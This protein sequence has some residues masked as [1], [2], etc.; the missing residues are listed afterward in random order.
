MLSFLFTQFTFWLEKCI[1]ETENLEERVAVL[2]RV[3][4]LLMVFDELNNFCGVIEVYSALTSAPVHRLEHTFDVCLI[5]VLCHLQ[6][7]ISIFSHCD[8]RMLGYITR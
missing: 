3:L 4:E 7:F 2:C 1:L 5:I 6:N 8:P